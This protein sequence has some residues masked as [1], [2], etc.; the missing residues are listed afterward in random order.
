MKEEHKYFLPA[1]LFFLLLKNNYYLYINKQ[2]V[3]YN[4]WF[5][6]RGII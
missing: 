5:S 4:R 2:A 3:K 6:K 1:I